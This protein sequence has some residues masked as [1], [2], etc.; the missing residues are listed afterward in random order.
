MIKR[1][2]ILPH[3]ELKATDKLHLGDPSKVDGWEVTHLLS[4]V[5]LVVI[6]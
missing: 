6:L 3:V 1:F 5:C 4:T 2:S